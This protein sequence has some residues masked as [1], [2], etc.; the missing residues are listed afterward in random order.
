MGQKL[1]LDE[2]QK[3]AYAFSLK[4]KYSICAMD[5]GQGKT[6]VAL[7]LAADLNKPCLIVCPASLILNWVDEINKWKWPRQLDVLVFTKK[8]QIVKPPTGL[9]IVSYDNA[10]NADL[11]FEWADFVIFDEG[12]NLKSMKAKRT[13]SIHRMIFE[14]SVKRI[15]ILTGTP[16]N[17][18]VE[19]FYSLISLCYYNPLFKDPGFLKEFPDSMTFADEFSFRKQYHI[20]VKTKRGAKFRMPVITWSKVRNIPRLK[21]I[22]NPVYFRSKGTPGSYSVKEI[23]VEGKENKELLDAFKKFDLNPEKT[24]PPEKV[25]AAQLMVKNTI[26]YAKLVQDETNRPVVIFSD[27]REP[28]KEIAA[29]LGVPCLSGAMKASERMK[30]ALEFQKGGMK[31]L[32]AT[33]RALGIGTNLTASY[34]LILN[35]LPWSAGLFM[36]VIKRID[37]K[38]Q[39]KKP[40]IHLMQGSTQT[41]LIYKSL[42][43]KMVT[44]DRAT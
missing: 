2:I 27:H 40:V 18:R 20:E 7:Q 24:N 14:N 19:E 12:Q 34:N 10:V 32:V 6:A 44:I 23:I 35:D 29:A 1:V 39:T 9:A 4:H 26:Q 8:K 36:Q 16:I 3:R 30:I 41:R 33:C 17:N 11:L 43:E 25:L 37:R 21:K 31:Y 13:S 15:M 28:A 22:L 42:M 38:G 5:M